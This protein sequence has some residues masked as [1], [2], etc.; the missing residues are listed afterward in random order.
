MENLIETIPGES[1][2][3]IHTRAFSHNGCIVDLGCI[4]WDWSK[5]LIGSKRVIG[6]DPFETT[7]PEG[8]EL[9]KGVVTSYDGL[10][11]MKYLEFASQ[12]ASTQEDSEWYTALSWKSFCKQYDIDEIS[13]LKM[14]IEGAEY[15]LLHSMDTDDFLK[16]DQLIVS[17]HNW[18]NPKWKELTEAS[19]YLL[20][21][22]GFSV[23]ENI[24]PYGWHMALK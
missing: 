11:K 21:R 15:S 5:K 17:F 12:I 16:I 20:K 13:I 3:R 23:I 14:N 18:M 8:A 19:I 1:Y 2:S 24:G 9:F 4:E 22:N 7:I 6:V 10:I